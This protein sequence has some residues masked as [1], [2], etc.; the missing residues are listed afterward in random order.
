MERLG[1]GPEVLLEDNPRLVY[2]RVTGYGQTGPLA[3]SAGHDINYLAMSGVLGAMRR[4][5]ER[6]LFPLNLLGDYGGG[7]MVLAVGLLCGILEAR[8]SGKGQVVDAAIVDGAAQL[9]T[10]IFGFIG[11]G[12]WGSPGFNALD[13]GAPFYEV[14]ETADGGFVAV[15]AI[16]PQFYAALLSVLGI[17]PAEAPQWNRPGWPSLKRR[18][19]DV[20]RTRSR[21]AWASAVV[22][23]DACLTPV[24][25]PTEAP[26][27]PSNVARGVFHQDDDGFYLPAA[28]PRFSHTSPTSTGRS[29]ALHDELEEWGVSV[30]D[31]ERLQGLGS[32]T[33]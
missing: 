7:G 33:E 10:L 11:D 28:A 3:Q 1:L 32:L 26:L 9:G 2:G 14:Y 29:T 20:F 12:S 24:L 31:I 17:D 23:V 8:Q 30:P 6:P 5:G 18:F 21:D 15:G 16:E 27:H 25:L 13:S 22:G 19:A 4:E